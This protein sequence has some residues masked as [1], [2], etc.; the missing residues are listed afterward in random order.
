MFDRA[1]VIR[2]EDYESPML[3][4]Q[5]LT[6]LDRHEQAEA[7][8][9]KSAHLV[10][11]HLEFNPEDTRALILGATVFA[12]LKDEAKAVEYAERAIS[13]DRDDPMLLYNVAC[14]YAQL[15]RL[16]DAMDALEHAVERGWGD[17][18]WIEHDSD[19][20]AIR[21]MPRYKSLLQAM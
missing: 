18:A 12:N 8:Y 6:A 5:A 1:S 10:D 21:D 17:R 11:Q 16:D 2:P 15:G 7:I 20:D 9:R 14:T 4:G 3:G 13:V 19:L